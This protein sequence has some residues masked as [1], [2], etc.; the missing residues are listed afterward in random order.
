MGI[1]AINKFCPKKVTF[2][3]WGMGSSHSKNKTNISLIIISIIIKLYFE[4]LFK[5]SVGEMT[6]KVRKGSGNDQRSE[7]THYF[8]VSTEPICSAIC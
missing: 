6:G 3:V 8:S 5:G 7:I 2:W 1:F 4:A